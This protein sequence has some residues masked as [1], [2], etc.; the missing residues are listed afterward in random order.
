MVVVRN[1]TMS[2]AQY[3]VNHLRQIQLNSIFLA[4][5]AMGQDEFARVAQ[6]ELELLR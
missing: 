6:Q 3:Q 1:L 2:N 5:V 4:V